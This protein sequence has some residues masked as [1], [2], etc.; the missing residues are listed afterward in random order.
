MV[1]KTLIIGRSYTTQMSFLLI[2]ITY[3]TSIITDDDFYFKNF[4]LISNN[5]FKLVLIMLNERLY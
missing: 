2:L 3:D 1:K 4:K 5:I